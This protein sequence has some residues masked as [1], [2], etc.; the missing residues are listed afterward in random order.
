[1]RRQRERGFTLIELLVVMTIIGLLSAAVMLAL[2]DTGGSL[3]DEAER[4]AARAHAARDFAITG[5]RSVGI[6][7]GP[8]AYAF[9]RRRGAEWQALAER[10]F[11]QEAWKKGTAVAFNGRGAGRIVFD[12]TGLAEPA[13]LTL[14]RG[15]R[16][17]TVDVAADGRIDVAS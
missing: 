4:F 7:V 12:S 8:A 9:Q 5:S 15:K 10:P 13:R 1:V 14:V 2:P 3:R 6:D 17:V 11:R 16:Q